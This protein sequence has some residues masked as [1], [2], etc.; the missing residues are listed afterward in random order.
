[1]RDSALPIDARP[2][3]DRGPRAGRPPQDVAG[4]LGTHI[5]DVALDQFTRHGIEGT[6]MEGIAAAAQVSKRTLYLRYGSKKGL[7]RAIIEPDRASFLEEIRVEE[8]A[9]DPRQRLHHAACRM[10]DATLTPRAIR[11]E[12]LTRQIAALEPGRSQPFPPQWTAP[13]IGVFRSIIAQCDGLADEGKVKGKGKGKGKDEGELDFLA[14]HLFDMLITVP[15]SRILVRRELANTP[16]AK[17]A[18][19]E[20]ALDLLIEGLPFLKAATG[21]VHHPDAG[22]SS[23]LDGKTGNAERQHP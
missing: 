14:G 7:L 18:Y 23:T 20:R 21:P 19:I 1:M 8:L 16:K 6:S 15:R 9:A 10:L 13:W 17:A 12:A 11:F 22:T 3:P 5:L 4:R 2:L